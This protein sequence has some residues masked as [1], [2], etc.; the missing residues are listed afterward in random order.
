MNVCGTPPCPT[1]TPIYRPPVG[2]QGGGGSATLT[3]AGRT[4][5]LLQTGCVPHGS[6]HQ[7]V[8]TEVAGQPVG[9]RRAAPRLSIPHPLP[10]RPSHRARDRYSRLP[11]RGIGGRRFVAAIVSALCWFCS[12]SACRVGCSLPPLLRIII[13]P[14]W[15]ICS[16]GGA[17]PLQGLQP[18]NR[19]SFLIPSPILSM[20]KTRHLIEIRDFSEV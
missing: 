7:P 5:Q 12:A 10:P 1:T 15:R 13:G 20:S 9:R 14:I 18:A 2:G 3:M 4:L 11:W 17:L 16:A 6:A 8:G 19:H